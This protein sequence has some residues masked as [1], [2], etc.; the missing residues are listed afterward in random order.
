MRPI[1]LLSCCILS[2]VVTGCSGPASEEPAETPSGESEFTVTVSSPESSNV[3]VGTHKMNPGGNGSYIYG[4]SLFATSY[5]SNPAVNL[6]APM[7]CQFLLVQITGKLESGTQW[8]LRIEKRDDGSSTAPLPGTGLLSYT[9]VCPDEKD[10]RTWTAVSGTLR[11]DSMGTADPRVTP[12]GAP[13]DSVKTM[14]FTLVDVNM[15]PES[16]NVNATGTFLL[17]GRGRVDALSGMDKP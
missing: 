12:A 11:V 5:G 4:T 15:V 13:A 2:L 3:T 9:E 6:P 8:P 10:K 7:P 1:T 14:T 17:Q 16:K